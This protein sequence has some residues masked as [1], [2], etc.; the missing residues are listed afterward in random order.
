MKQQKSTEKLQIN[1]GDLFY[2]RLMPQLCFF[3]IMTRYESYTDDLYRLYD[4]KT[5]KKIWYS[6]DWIR[7]R[8]LCDNWCHQKVKK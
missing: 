1:I 7:N 8:I 5:K 6:Y 4:Y 3:V 2:S